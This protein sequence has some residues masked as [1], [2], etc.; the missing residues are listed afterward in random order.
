M[1]SHV[2]CILSA[3]SFV[4]LT[5]RNKHNLCFYFMLFKAHPTHKNNLFSVHTAGTIIS[6]DKVTFFIWFSI[7]YLQVA[8]YQR[9]TGAHSD[10]KMQNSQCRQ[11]VGEWLV[12]PPHNI[13][14]L[15]WP[16]WCIRG[17]LSVNENYLVP[18]S[19]W[20]GWWIEGRLLRTPQTG[21]RLNVPC[22]AKYPQK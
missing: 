17:D 15:Y 22:C 14:L 6:S 21:G 20:N 1:F 3:I 12:S 7:H 18:T 2:Q 16:C 11:K 8:E 10:T 9:V 13:V 4:T 19:T 5:F